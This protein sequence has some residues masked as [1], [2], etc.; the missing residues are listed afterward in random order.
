MHPTVRQLVLVGIPLL[1][2]TGVILET[3]MS[4]LDSKGIALGKPVQKWVDEGLFCEE[5]RLKSNIL[6]PVNAW[7]AFVYNLVGLLALY[8]TPPPTAY[9]HNFVY[10]TPAVRYLFYG[11]YVFMGIGSFYFHASFTFLGGIFDFSSIAFLA[12]YLVA[13]SITR[14]YGR[15]ATLFFISFGI[16]A[17][18]AVTLRVVLDLLF[19]YD[20]TG[21]VLF[22]YLL[23]AFAS[24][25][26]RQ[27]KFRKSGAKEVDQN[28]GQLIGL[29]GTESQPLLASNHQD[30]HGINQ[31]STKFYIEDW[32][33]ILWAF[34]TL[35][36]AIVLW[37]LDFFDVVCFPRQSLQLH[38]VWHGLTCYSGIFF[39]FY[40][41]LFR[42][43]R[44]I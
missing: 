25:T 14:W 19:G 18:V 43:G 29:E 13:Y 41:N 21:P 42:I 34:V 37:I 26:Y 39:F 23:G 22:A 7:S 28:T 5:L 3:I 12:S 35:M 9:I 40:I 44:E 30:Q 36:L 15:G 4:I 24:E 6:Q 10:T 1:L 33:W 27:V 32:G 16:L 2:A 17:T 38:A 31:E 11:V 20:S 8:I